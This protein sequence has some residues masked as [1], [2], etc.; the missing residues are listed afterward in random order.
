MCVSTPEASGMIWTP[1]D[2]LNKIYSFY[3]AAVV[4][5][6]SR[7]GLIIEAYCRNQLNKSKLAM[8]KPLI[9]CNSC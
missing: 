9:H 3:V 4:G 5:I 7:C 6:V 1:Y 8:C 2:W